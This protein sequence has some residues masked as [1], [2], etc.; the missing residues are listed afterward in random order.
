M[1]NERS[2]VV[3]ESVDFRFTKALPNVSIPIHSILIDSPGIND[4]LVLATANKLNALLL[5]EVWGTC[6]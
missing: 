6:R 5:T 1:K 3:D 4:D 2:V